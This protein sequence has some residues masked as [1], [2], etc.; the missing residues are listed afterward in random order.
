[1]IVN[2]NLK[3]Q[4]IYEAVHELIRMALPSYTV[5]VAAKEIAD[6]YIELELHER[7]EEIRVAGSIWNAERCIETAEEVNARIDVYQRRAQIKRVLARCVY[8]LLSEFLGRSINSYGILTGMR[9]VKLIHKFLNTGKT[10]GEISSLLREEYLLPEEKIKLLLEVA[11]NNREFLHPQAAVGIPIYLYIGIPFCPSRCYYCSFPGA[12]TKDYSLEIKPFLASLSTEI[13]AVSKQ[14]KSQGS[15][16]QAIYMGGGT[17]SILNCDD[18]EMLFGKLRECF[19]FAA[20]DFEF[21]I[22]AGRPDTITTD[23]LELFKDVGINRICVNPQTSNDLTLARIGRKHSWRQIIDV[24]KAV[25]KVGID[26]I[27]MD[28]ILG[29]PGEEQNDFIKSAQE[30]LEL[31]PDNITIHSLAVKKGSD[32]ALDIGRTEVEESFSEVRQGAA[33]LHALFCKSGYKPYYLYRQKYA[34]GDM[35]NIGYGLP[36]TYCFY[37]IQVIEEV[38]TIIGLGGGASSKFI[39]PEHSAISS[40]YNPKNPHAYQQGLKRLI[41]HKVD[42]LTSLF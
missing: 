21:T 3:P 14:L 15:Y 9:P 23:K 38:N 33:R 7:G 8:K 27:N 4:S 1:M 42:K 39:N 12:I 26:Y 17:P 30:V 18:L 13:E 40:L 24:V 6:L 5:A 41:A 20:N 37:N 19:L 28:L 11:A 35:D 16:I 25:R 22:E 10:A 31:R 2:L 34:K 32:L 36:G 29:L